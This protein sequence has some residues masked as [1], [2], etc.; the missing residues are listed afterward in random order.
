MFQGV[1][2]T[3]RQL[4]LFHA[5]QTKL[6]EDTE[7]EVHKCSSKQ[8]LL[9]ISQISL[10]KYMCWSLCLRKFGPL[11]CNLL[12]ETPTL[13]FSCQNCCFLFQ[14][15]NSNNLF[16]H[17]Q[18]YLLRTTNLWSPATLT[19]TKK[20]ENAFTYQELVPI[21]RLNINKFAVLLPF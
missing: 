12:K 17:F 7:A 1:L 4:Y 13:V 6:L 18:R 15:S 20:F 9:K 16:K 11:T 5:L 19:M 10:E 21:E 2:I 3:P 8:E 14:I